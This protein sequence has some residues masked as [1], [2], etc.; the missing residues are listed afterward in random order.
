MKINLIGVIMDTDNIKSIS[1]I[2]PP[3]AEMF[4]DGQFSHDDEREWMDR[5]VVQ[6]FTGSPLT[7]CKEDPY[8]WKNRMDFKKI[9]ADLMKTW[10]PHQSTIPLMGTL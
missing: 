10:E 8:I 9:H 3:R 5:F 7:I 6:F 2:I 1:E 4:N